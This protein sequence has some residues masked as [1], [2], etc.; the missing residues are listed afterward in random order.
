MYFWAL[1]FVFW[2]VQLSDNFEPPYKQN[3]EWRLMINSSW[4]FSTERFMAKKI[5]KCKKK[6]LQTQLLTSLNQHIS[7]WL[8]A[9]LQKT[10]FEHSWWRTW[11]LPVSYSSSSPMLKTGLTPLYGFPTRSLLL[12]C[13]K[14]RIKKTTTIKTAWKNKDF[15]PALPSFSGYGHF[16]EHGNEMRSPLGLERRVLLVERKGS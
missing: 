3:P 2:E 16:K 14:Q 4:S 13:L 9:A 1:I 12:T 7:G 11:Y 5:Y 15:T 6:C 10:Q 8:I